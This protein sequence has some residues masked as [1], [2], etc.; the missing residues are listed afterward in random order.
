MKRLIVA[1][2]L[3]IAFATTSQAGVKDP[4]EGDAFE[5]LVAA[6]DVELQ[7]NLES[8]VPQADGVFVTGP[9]APLLERA[10]EL[11]KS[12]RV[13][14]C[15]PIRPPAGAKPVD[16]QAIDESR[17]AVVSVE[18]DG[19]KAKVVFLTVAQNRWLVWM[20]DLYAA[21]TVDVH[22]QEVH[23][24]SDA[25]WRHLHPSATTPPPR[26]VDFGLPEAADFYAPE[27]DYV[28]EGYQNYKDALHAHEEVETSF[29]H[30]ILGFVPGD[31]LLEA[32]KSSAPQEAWPN[33]EEPLLQHEYKKYFERGGDTTELRTLTAEVLQTLKP[34]E[35]F[36]CV[37][38]DGEIRF[39]YEIPREEVDRI[40]RE[41]GKK[42]PRANHAFLFP[43]EPVLTAG[44]F[45]VAIEGGKRR[46]VEVN[47][48]SGH[49]FY[50]NVTATIRE[51][52]ALRSD[53]YL[54]TLGHFF[55]ALER[56]GIEHRRVLVT[57]M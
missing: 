7:E 43:G 20:R 33:K 54:M 47:A 22:S 13:V 17:G 12:V 19:R 53:E 46:I 21:G 34:G 14:S 28:I 52:I 40:E 32:M 3:V 50:S 45:L 15:R 49:Y 37:G 48:H 57:K 35:Y 26:A 30:G 8:I 23:E 42:V 5:A 29:A 2:A 1:V 9:I 44:A 38:L 41:T 10:P 56:L 27:P 18:I 36:Y 39:G 51:D 55:A 6:Q 16:P 11:M 31:S 4:I 25:V 24:Y